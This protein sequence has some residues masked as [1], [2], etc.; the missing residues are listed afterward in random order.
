MV[1]GGRIGRSSIHLAVRILGFLVVWQ[2][3]QE[4]A[5]LH[6]AAT[7]ENS[8]K[9][10]STAFDLVSSRGYISEWDSLSL[11]NLSNRHPA[12]PPSALGGRPTRFPA[13][14]DAPVEAIT[15]QMAGI[16]RAAEAKIRRIEVSDTRAIFACTPM[17]HSSANSIVR[18]PADINCLCIVPIVC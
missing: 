12:L 3:R 5:V 17:P 9:G 14:A 2:V 6:N 1:Q 13:R 15:N 4:H 8:A 11:R 7:M 10:V 18:N 16:L